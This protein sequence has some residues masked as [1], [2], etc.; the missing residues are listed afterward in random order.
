[1]IHSSHYELSPR[2]RNASDLPESTIYVDHN[3][4]DVCSILGRKKGYNAGNFLRLPEALHWASCKE[5]LR[6]FVAGFLWPL[7]PVQ[8]R[9]SDGPGSHGVDTNAAPDEFGS[10]RSGE[11][12]NA[13]LVG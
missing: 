5:L 8:N 13:A 1:M 10:R 6:P 7:V 11:E 4:D 2:N 9:S 12:R 3:A